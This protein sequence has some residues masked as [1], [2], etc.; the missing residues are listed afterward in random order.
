MVLIWLC[1]VTLLCRSCGTAMGCYLND[2][3]LGIV[4]F[5]PQLNPVFLC[6]TVFYGMEI[7]SSQC[8]TVKR[9]PFCSCNNPTLILEPGV[10]L[11]IFYYKFSQF[12]WSLLET[13][14]TIFI[15]FVSKILTVHFCKDSLI[16]DDRYVWLMPSWLSQFCC[17]CV[18]PLQL[19]WKL[20]HP[21]FTLTI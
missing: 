13:L 8:T 18:L 15:I 7:K 10:S 21:D 19:S 20:F 16:K 12:Q 9:E 11:Y 3:Q 14:Q 2:M 4:M 1:T 17:Y 6:G 5:S